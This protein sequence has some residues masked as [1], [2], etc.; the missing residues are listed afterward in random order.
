[1]HSIPMIALPIFADQGYTALRIERTGRG[2]NLDV[3]TLTEKILG[4]AITELL[5]NNT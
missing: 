3:N 5:T 1:M 4:D 2:I